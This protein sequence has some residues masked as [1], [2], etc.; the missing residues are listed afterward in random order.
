MHEFYSDTQT[1]PTR[2]MRE[3]ALNVTLGD[4]RHNED[5]STNELCARVADMLGMEAAVF[6][7]S[8][9]MC[10]EIAIAVHTRPGDE[11]ICTRESHIIFA[12]SGGPAA[13]SG[14][15]MCPIDT[16]RGMLSPEQVIEH[17]R[18]VSAHAPR[19][20]LLLAEQTANLAGGAVWPL[21]QLNATVEA[22]KSAGLST[23]LD[24]ARLLNAQVATGVAVAEYA[25]GFDSAWIAFTKGLGCP[26]GAVLAGSHD[27]ISKAWLLKRR[28]GG[29]MRQ[30]GVLTAMCLYALDNHIDRLADD[31]TLAQFIGVR[32]NELEI[33]S[34]ILPID[35]NIVIADLAPDGPDAREVAQQLKRKNVTITV[36]GPRRIRIVT[37]MDVGEAD[38][39]ALVAAMATVI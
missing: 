13:L 19:S 9:T 18:P 16:D 29:A 37:H 14:V 31:H 34:N 30:T 11:V 24:G 17:V 8:G 7:P 39:D 25:R 23:H 36:V 10:N 28:W 35:T 32:L 38:A 33:I 1:R 3:S 12:E 5:P 22:A 20:R 21:E 27:F 26:V 2:A 6:L 4:E 15:M